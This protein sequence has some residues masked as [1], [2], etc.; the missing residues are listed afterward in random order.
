TA[1]LEIVRAAKGRW[2]VPL[3]AAYT[4]SELVFALPLAWIV[5]DRTF[6]NP[7]F[8][9]A[10]S[11]DGVTIPGGIYTAAALV[12]LVIAATE[13]VHRFREAAKK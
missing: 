12:I 6:F 5:Y 8:L 3:A 7:E 1:V 9:D 11:G 13:S 4:V 10:V 2:N